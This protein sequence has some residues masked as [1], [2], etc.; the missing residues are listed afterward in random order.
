MVEVRAPAKINLCLR[1]GDRRP[2]G[3]HP[4][5]TLMEKVDLY[6]SL[7]IEE[8]STGISIDGAD[9]PGRD[10]TVSRALAA[11]EQEAGIPV[12]VAIE[13]RKHIPVAAGLAGGSSDAAA[14]IMAVSRLFSLEIPEERLMRIALGVGADVPF[15]LKAGPCLATGIGEQLQQIESLPGYSIVLVNPGRELSTAAV[16][17]A[18]DRSGGEGAEPVDACTGRL[19]RVLAAGPGLEELAG[20]MVNDLEISAFS[21][22]PEIASIK[23][24]LLGLGAAGALMSGSG[25]SVFGIFADAGDARAAAE[26]LRSGYER[27]WALKPL[28]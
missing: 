3:Y 8:G 12:P 27:V 28:R 22:V 11:L 20:L 14:A 21:M 23:N 9:L 25:P 2:D 7:S 26:S 18:F 10:N 24:H 19:R 17:D 6:D 5:C 15:F 1:V 4:L 16:Y 13:L